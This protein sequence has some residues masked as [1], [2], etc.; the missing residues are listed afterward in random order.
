MSR[1]IFPLFDLKWQ[2]RTTTLEEGQEK[3]LQ[4]PGKSAA[5]LAPLHGPIMLQPWSWAPLVLAGTSGFLQSEGDERPLYSDGL[6]G[7]W[8][9]WRILKVL[10]K[11]DLGREGY[12]T[13]L[14]RL[15]ETC[16]NWIKFRV[17]GTSLE[18]VAGVFSRPEDTLPWRGQ[19][20]FLLRAHNTATLRSKELD[21]YEL[22]V[23]DARP[24]SSGMVLC[25]RVGSAM[26]SLNDG[27]VGQG[28]DVGDF[29]M[30]GYIN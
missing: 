10:G 11:A 5:R 9:A 14:A 25:H 2:G 29:Y 4:H 16:Y 26:G 20:L 21:Y 22:V 19:E 30:D 8:A 12:S 7:R 17:E 15:T 27:N 1:A 6:R 28:L 24:H 13:R 23:K 18:F 3:L